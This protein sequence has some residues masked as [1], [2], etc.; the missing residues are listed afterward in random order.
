MRTSY[1]LKKLQRARKL[2]RQRSAFF[3]VLILVLVMVAHSA[4][5][6]PENISD[7]YDVISVTVQEGD[8]LWSI[9]SEYKPEGAD[10]RQ[11]VYD[12]A[13]NN[14]IEDCQIVSGQTLFIPVV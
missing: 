3:M 7:E 14:G 12:I 13:A 5:S 2:R 6:K 8:T 9:A 10:L 1:K 11:F 4:F